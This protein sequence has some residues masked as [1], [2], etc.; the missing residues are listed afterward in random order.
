MSATAYPNPPGTS[1]GAV[2]TVVAVA[3]VAR[4]GTPPFPR[5]RMRLMP[6]KVGSCPVGGREVATLT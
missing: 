2:S 1:D 6:I 5:P 3:T 4:P